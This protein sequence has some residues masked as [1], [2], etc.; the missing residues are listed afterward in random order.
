MK[1]SIIIP[2]Y[3]EERRLGAML[4]QYLAFFIPRYGAEVEFLIVVN[5]SVD[6][7]PEIARDYAARN[8]VVR[9][10]IEPRSIGKGGAV[11]LGFAAAQGALMGFVDADGATPPEAFEDLAASINDADAIIA[12]R[13]LPGAE[14]RSRRRLSRVLASRVFNALV[15]SF[16]KLQITDTQCGAKLLKRE[17]VQKILPLLGLTRWAFD[18]DL[19]FQLRRAGLRIT[20]RPTVWQDMAGSRLKVGRA[21]LEMFLAI[22]RLRLLHSPL[23]WVVSLYDATLGRLFKVAT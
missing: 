3:N 7:T 2:A 17:A 12:S 22:C 10:I 9:V 15:R 6:R 16:F 14:I 13:W 11:M 19:L 4:E 18:V 23:R 8:P 20:E 21:S 1:L 5:G